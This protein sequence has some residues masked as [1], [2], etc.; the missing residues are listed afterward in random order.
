MKVFK[1]KWFHRWA[2]KER[3]GDQALLLAVEE[4]VN[5]LIDADLGGH[6]IKKRV[7]ISGRGKRGSLRTLVAFNLDDKVFFVYGFAKNERANIS[8]KELKTL[9]ELAGGVAWL[10]T[11]SLKESD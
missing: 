7:A 2:A 10:S 5:G 9:K 3:L 1:T 8:L 4:I 6:V 11:C